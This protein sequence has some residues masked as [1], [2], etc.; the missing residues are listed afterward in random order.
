[1]KFRVLKDKILNQK[2]LEEGY[3][4][5]SFLNSD[6]VHAARELFFRYHPEPNIKGLYSPTNSLNLKQLLD[7]H[8][9]LREIFSRSVQKYVDDMQCIGGTFLAKGYDPEGI[10]HPHQDWSIVD[11]RYY[12]SY[13]I[14][15]ALQDTTDANGALY[16]LPRSHELVRG[17]RHVTI[18]SV[19][20]KIY[21]LTWKYMVSLPLKAGEAVIFD[22]A[23]GHASKPNLTKNIRLAATNSL[24]S[25]QAEYRFYWN[26]N[27][28]VEEYEGEPYYYISEEAKY[29][30][31]KLKKLRT[32]DYTIHQLSEEEFKKL[33][34]KKNIFYSFWHK[35]LQ[36]IG[37]E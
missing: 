27:G 24:I 36:R 21:Q 35:A 15:A 7:I 29:G 9:E 33:F 34:V 30:P 6:E 19:F 3:V 28:V 16:V 14:W 37:A 2:L 31:G 12:R 26:N 4:V 17:F 8:H 18:P 10:L 1:M 32:L 20:G 23:L 22:H 11:E 25:P 5:L 13:T